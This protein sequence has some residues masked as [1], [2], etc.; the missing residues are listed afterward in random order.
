MSTPT[1]LPQITDTARRVI[2]TII[3]TGIPTFLAL[4]G[5][6]PYALAQ[7]QGV[8]SPDLY[9]KLVALAGV[10]TAAAGVLAKIMANPTVNTILA[11]VRLN[12]STGNNI[13]L[14]ADVAMPTDTQIVNLKQDN[15]GEYTG[16]PAY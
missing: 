14:G 12:S 3:Q 10:I 9:L 13:D 1:D 5:I 4:A 8:V 11:K 2:R 15:S 16:T 6:V 7:A